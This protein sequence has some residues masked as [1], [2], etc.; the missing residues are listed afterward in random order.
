MWIRRAVIVLMLAL[1]ALPVL[2]GPAS[3]GGRPTPPP[4][5]LGDAIVAGLVAIGAIFL[6]VVAIGIAN[7]RE[8]R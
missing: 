3:A 1:L 8:H 6:S 7:R 4:P 2:A 5:W